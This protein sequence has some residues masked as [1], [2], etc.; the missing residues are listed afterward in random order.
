MVTKVLNGERD[1]VVDSPRPIRPS[2]RNAPRDAVDVS[3]N[4]A[5]YKAKQ[6][7]LRLLSYRARSRVEVRRRLEKSYPPAVIEQ[8]LAQLSDQ[9]YLDDAA[10]AREWRR[11]REERRPRS[12]RALEHE[13]LRL[14]VEREIVQDALA[15]YDAAGNAYRAALRLAH[16]LNDADYP[17]FRTKVWRHLQR[18]GFETSIITDVVG[19]LWRELADPHHCAVDPYPQEHKRKDA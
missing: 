7:A 8:V 2:H 17:E 9:V 16:R 10:F 11:S 12:Q 3:L 5:H 1:E 6:A 14:G 15:G 13:L 19:R 18:R 4:E